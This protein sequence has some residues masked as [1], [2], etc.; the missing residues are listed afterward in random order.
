MDL[1]LSAR[2]ATL[3]PE[4]LCLVHQIMAEVG[5]HH[6]HALIHPLT[7]ASEPESKVIGKV[8]GEQDHMIKM[9]CDL[10]DMCLDVGAD[11]RYEEKQIYLWQALEPRLLELYD[12]TGDYRAT[13]MLKERKKLDDK[14]LLAQA[15]LDFQSSNVHAAEA[16]E[17]YNSV[18]NP[19][20]VK[21]LKYV[22]LSKVIEK[23]P[24]KCSICGKDFVFEQ[25]MQR[26]RAMACQPQEAAELIDI[27]FK[28][29]GDEVEKT[30]RVLSAALQPVQKVSE[31]AP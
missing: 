15:Q 25:N 26:H 7:E 18:E 24:H 1:Q 4:V 21:T 17:Q 27:G 10:V 2:V 11:A 20:T 16:L 9:I 5:K 30:K 3:R 29:D 12:A 22:P 19:M 13:K 23:R 14:D 6:M 28:L 8:Y 31:Q